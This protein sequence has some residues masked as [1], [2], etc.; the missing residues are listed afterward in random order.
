MVTTK[1]VRLEDYT[2]LPVED[3][4]ARATAFYHE[5][6]KRRSVRVFSDKT[7]PIDIIKDCLRTAGTA[8]SG[9]NQQPWHFVVVKDSAIKRKIRQEAEKVERKFYGQTASE[10]FLS[11]L[12]PI[13]TGPEKGFLETA[14]Y[15]IVIFMQR[16]GLTPDGE[17]V[18]HC[19][20][21]ESVGIATGILIAAIHHVGLVSLPYTPN[22]MSFLSTILK[23]PENERPV[24][25]I[26]VGYPEETATVPKLERKS[27]DEI[28]SF[29]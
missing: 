4:K 26:P 16:Y 17:K 1:S 21:I 10:G 28:A 22:P 24:M 12:A 11:A 29:I 2:P 25:I 14:P 3:M 7:I 15:L 23:R 8:P 19:Y 20:P 18:P 13:D 5:M 27:F 6:R 9:A